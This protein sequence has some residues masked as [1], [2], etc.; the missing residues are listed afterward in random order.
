MTSSAQPSSLLSASPSVGQPP[1]SC[2]HAKP[3]SRFFLP[4][5]FPARIA[6]RY[7]AGTLF[8]LMAMVTHAQALGSLID[9]A[10]TFAQREAAAQDALQAP[11]P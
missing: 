2:L 4:I 7:C 9:I 10:Q 6:L 8:A 11:I 5:L 1:Q 3:T